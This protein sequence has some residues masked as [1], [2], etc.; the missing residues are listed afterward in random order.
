MANPSVAEL[1]HSEK[2]KFV[3]R[4]HH[5][6]IKEFVKQRLSEGGKIVF[7][8]MV[9][10]LLMTLT[11]LFFFTRAMLKAFNGFWEPLGFSLAALVFSF[12]LLIVIHELLHAFALKLTGAPVINFGAYFKK[13]IFYAE[14]DRHVL[15]GKQFTLVALTP[16]FVVQFVTAIALFFCINHPFAYFIIMVMS[17]HSLFCA[18]DIGLFSVFYEFDEDT[19]FIFDVKEERCSCFYEKVQPKTD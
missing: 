17:I 4:L 19:L 1:Q 12:T 8:F 11:G 9:Y 13:F 6:Q 2:Y 3:F 7:L 10:Q 15:N 16:L 14:A 5:N 18:G